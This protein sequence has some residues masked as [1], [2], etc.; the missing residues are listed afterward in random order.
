MRKYKDHRSCA[1][2]KLLEAGS[3]A[4]LLCRG[5]KKGDKGARRINIELW[6][7]L[8]K[9]GEG[10]VVDLTE[11]D[12]M[13]LLP[14]PEHQSMVRQRALLY[15]PTDETMGICR[16]VHVGWNPEQKQIVGW[17]CNIQERPLMPKCGGYLT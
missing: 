7:K 16:L 2:V 13:E 17:F 9:G 3:A 6:S 8:K 4:G 15:D 11:E 1:N 5:R 10:E 12:E 14:S